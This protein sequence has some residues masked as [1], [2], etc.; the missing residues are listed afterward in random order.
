MEASG[1]ISFYVLAPVLFGQDLSAEF[2]LTT[3]TP[4]YDQY[5]DNVH[6]CLTVDFNLFPEAGVAAVVP[7]IG[8]MRDGRL[9]PW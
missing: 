9:R 6:I 1:L 7:G 4:P 2:S 5:F 3:K 8:R